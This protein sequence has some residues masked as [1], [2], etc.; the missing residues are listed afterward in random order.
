MKMNKKDITRNNKLKK[1]NSI[2]TK[3]IGNS[4][5]SKKKYQNY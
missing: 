5:Y 3:L 4:V 2:Q 1:N